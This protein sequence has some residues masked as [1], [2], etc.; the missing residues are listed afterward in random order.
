MI[1][2]CKSKEKEKPENIEYIIGIIEEK[3][4][5]TE[6]AYY[7]LINDISLEN[8]HYISNDENINFNF[9]P[10]RKGIARIYEDDM[11]LNITI[12]Y[13]SE[14]SSIINLDEIE[15]NQI[16]LDIL[17]KPF[18][19]SELKILP[20]YLFEKRVYK[21]EELFYIFGIYLSQDNINNF[22]NINYWNM[23]NIKIENLNIY[24]LNEGEYYKLYI[25]EYD[26]NIYFEPIIKI[27][28]T[29]YEIEE[30]LGVPTAYSNE[31]NIYIYESKRT[32]RQ[33]NVIFDDDE[34]V[35]TV[36]LIAYPGI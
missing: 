36:Q 33:I 14:S 32:L 11:I 35:K 25:V 22:K 2:S 26:N 7:L 5:I 30:K 4:N 20:E 12:I 17:D 6:G 13:K 10:T 21:I 9:N 16:I 24:V 18:E 15:P 31:R 8:Q 28:Y 29:K 3:D 27:G 23:V 34:K 19:N 1:I